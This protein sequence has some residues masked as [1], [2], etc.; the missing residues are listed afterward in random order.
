MTILHVFCIFCHVLLIMGRYF[1][2][3]HSYSSYLQY[4]EDTGRTKIRQEFLNFRG[5]R[6]KQIELECPS[7]ISHGISHNSEMLI[8]QDGNLQNR[9][10]TQTILHFFQYSVMFY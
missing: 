4:M 10:G 9:R 6:T 8:K 1:C 5:F 2:N 7:G 3:L